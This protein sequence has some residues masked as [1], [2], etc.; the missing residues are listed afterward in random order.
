[1]DRR[2]LV[3]DRKTLL[4]GIF[5]LAAALG[6]CCSLQEHLQ[7][8]IEQ[9]QRA[10]GPVAGQPR[11]QITIEVKLEALSRALPGLVHDRPLFRQEIPLGPLKAGVAIRLTSL[12]LSASNSCGGC[13]SVKA[14][15][16]VELESGLEGLVAAKI[17]EGALEFDTA[18]KATL[19]PQGRTV[20]SLDL[21][22]PAL[23]AFDL[24]VTALP[25]QIDRKLR[26]A[27]LALVAPIA[28]ALL[29]DVEVLALKPMDLGVGKLELTL[30]GIRTQAAENLIALDLATNLPGTAMGFR[31]DPQALA[32]GTSG[33]ALFQGDARVRLGASLPGAAIRNLLGSGAFLRRFSPSFEPD[34]A[35]PY[36]LVFD[37]LDFSRA[38]FQASFQLWHVDWPCWIAELAARGLIEPSGHGTLIARLEGIEVLKASAYQDRIRD[39][40]KDQARLA[41]EFARVS[42]RFLNEQILE[43]PG[44]LKLSWTPVAYR[45][46]RTAIEII[47]LFGLDLNHTP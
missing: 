42:E 30:V 33:T 35:G 43:G 34:P 8:A 4:G 3:V 41:G 24:V 46:D 44:G 15:C 38:G 5:F 11:P 18:L 37:S 40:L 12:A 39:E 20:I 6:G 32:L 9:E 7:A 19:Q 31:Q 36:Q 45:L 25:L 47:G 10:A 28:Q 23:K 16:A 14:G 13:L 1:M 27:L 17:A 29:S 26:E 2:D 22:H 21:S